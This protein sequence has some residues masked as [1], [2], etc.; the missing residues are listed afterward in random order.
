MEAP[1]RNRLEE[2]LRT[3]H[4]VCYNIEGSEDAF[5]I[6]A[7]SA[8]IPKTQ[9]Q[10]MFITIGQNIIKSGCRKVIFDMSMLQFYYEPTFDWFFTVWK[11]RMF[12][13]GISCYRII[14]PHIEI[15]REGVEK[16][17]K[18]A[19]EIFPDEKY[20]EMDIQ[21]TD[22][23]EDALNEFMFTSVHH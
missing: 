16:S 15:I 9:F 19:Y 3:R 7:T 12:Y 6:E 23:V 17:R 8:H 13:H 18:K 21:Y 10:E 14:L 2:V 4:A 1:T 22:T 5:V 20:W 11:E